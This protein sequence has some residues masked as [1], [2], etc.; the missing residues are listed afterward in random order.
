MRQIKFRAWDKNINEM[1]FDF[2]IHLGKNTR[3]TPTIGSYDK[4][5]IDEYWNKNIKIMQFTGLL[6][7]NGKEIYEGDIVKVYVDETFDTDVG[8]GGGYF[9]HNIKVEAD[10]VSGCNLSEFI[11]WKTQTLKKEFE[12]E[13]ICNI[14]ENPNLLQ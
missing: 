14:Y 9:W 10:M 11:D 6:D 3:F 8:M 13:I 12:C 5:T 7:K 2:C 4:N 1:C